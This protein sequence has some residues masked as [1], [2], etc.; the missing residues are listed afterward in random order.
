MVEEKES[1]AEVAHG[2]GKCGQ[3]GTVVGLQHEVQGGEQ[4][5][6]QRDVHDRRDVRRVGVPFPQCLKHRDKRTGDDDDPVDHVAPPCQ[7]LLTVEQPGC[8][9][10]AVE[11]H[12]CEFSRFPV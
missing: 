10:A 6:C 12:H 2:L 3:L 5:G 1:A 8:I 7:P 4:H 11:I 9:T